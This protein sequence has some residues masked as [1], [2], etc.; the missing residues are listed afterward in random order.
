M[1]E[2]SKDDVVVSVAKGVAGKCSKLERLQSLGHLGRVQRL[3]FTGNGVP[4]AV[5]DAMKRTEEAVQAAL[6]V[7]LEF[8]EVD[9]DGLV[10]G[11]GFPEASVFD[12]ES[13]ACEVFVRGLERHLANIV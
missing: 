6:R 2:C 12:K 13:E 4:E 5:G 10:G 3:R 8:R 11:S 1:C 7:V 9:E